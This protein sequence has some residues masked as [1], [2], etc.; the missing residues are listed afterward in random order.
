MNRI[1]VFAPMLFICWAVLADS[2]SGQAIRV[3]GGNQL[4]NITTGTAG[5]QPT[6]VVNTA[7]TLRYQRQNVVTRITVGATCPGQRFS[8]KVLAVSPTAGVAAPEVTMTDGMP[9]ANF[10]T[11]IPTGNPK[12]SSCTLRYTASATYDQGNSTELGN[13]V[14]TVVYTLVAP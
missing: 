2:C 12:N 1:L 5:G 9:A 3:V 8:L 6:P 13:D 11:N 10:I 14:Y 7:C 4:V